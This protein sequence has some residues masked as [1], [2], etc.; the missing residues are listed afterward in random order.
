M[1][2]RCSSVRDALTL[3]HCYCPWG[4]N[5]PGWMPYTAVQWHRPCLALSPQHISRTCNTW[6]CCRTVPVSIH[7]V[8]FPQ[9]YHHPWGLMPMETAGKSLRAEQ[10]IRSTVWDFHSDIPW[11]HEISPSM[12]SSIL[13]LC[14][15]TL[16]PPKI[17]CIQSCSVFQEMPGCFF[18]VVYVFKCF[19]L[20]LHTS[21][22]IKE[23]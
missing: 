19:F 3:L 12:G 5:S 18:V 17:V 22:A 7:Y 16:F 20:L 11:E 15:T 14:A 4:W 6:C 2:V 23:K 1:P 9:E 10:V 8:C 21:D 13:F